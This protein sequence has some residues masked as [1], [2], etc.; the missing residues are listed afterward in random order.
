MKPPLAIALFGKWGSGKSFFMKMLEKHIKELSENQGFQE[1]TTAETTDVKPEDELFHRG[2]AHIRFNAWSYMDANL[3][4]GL[5]HSLFEKLNEYITDNTKGTVEKLKVQV[6]ITK[7]LDIL[8]SDLNHFK[9]KRS[10]LVHLKE[11]L[12]KERESKIL[13]YFK[14]INYDEAVS[15]FLKKNGYNDQQIKEMTPSSIKK[16]IDETINLVSFFKS[17]GYKRSLIT[18][19]I[20]ISLFVIEGILERTLASKVDFLKDAWFKI[21]TVFIP[22]ISTALTFLNN[23][24]KARK[25][26]DEYLELIDP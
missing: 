13:N 8:H 18:L 17:E 5:S 9:E 22:M 15:G 2:I 25:K 21:I 16:T 14:T 3:W 1:S 11:R 26:V 7:R 4:A 6:K 10:Q 19:T 12:E 24:L 20:I 23:W